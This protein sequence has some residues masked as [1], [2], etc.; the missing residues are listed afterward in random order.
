M[1]EKRDRSHYPVVKRRLHD[2]EPNPY[3]LLTPEERVDM[4]WQLAID[5]YLFMGVE[6][7]EPGAHRHVV[8]FGRRGTPG[9]EF[10][11]W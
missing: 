7:A 1:G 11:T 4:M 8:R 6:P 5:A 10:D 9:N 3:A 2:P